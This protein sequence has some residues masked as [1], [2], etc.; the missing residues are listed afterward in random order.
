M[1]SPSTPLPLERYIINR[2]TLGI[3]YPEKL[4]YWQGRS[5]WRRRGLR[6][7]GGVVIVYQQLMQCTEIERLSINRPSSPRPCHDI[8]LT[9]M[10][11]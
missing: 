7:G 8:E 11:L 9:L 10:I 6:S 3:S 2:V 5:Y 1:F 4:L